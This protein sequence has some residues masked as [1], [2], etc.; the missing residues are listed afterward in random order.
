MKLYRCKQDFALDAYD[1]DGFSLDEAIT[2]EAGEV[3]QRSEDRF[4]V[5]GGSET[6]HLENDHAWIEITGD[7]LG[8]FF[9]E[10]TDDADIG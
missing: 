2:I 3:F 5:V 6:I 8:Q 9:D 4:R 1:D 10:V 7:L